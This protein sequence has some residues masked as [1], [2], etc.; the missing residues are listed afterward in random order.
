MGGQAPRE[1]ARRAESATRR[2]AP[3]VV[4]R[5]ERPPHL[6]ASRRRRVGRS[7]AIAPYEDMGVL[8]INVAWACLMRARTLQ[9]TNDLDIGAAMTHLPLSDLPQRL[10]CGQVRCGIAGSRIRRS[11]RTGGRHAVTT[12]IATSRAGAADLQLVRRLARPDRLYKCSNKVQASVHSRRMGPAR[13]RAWTMWGRVR[14][15]VAGRDAPTPASLVRSLSARQGETASTKSAGRRVR[16]RRQPAWRK[17][18][19][20]RWP[21]RRRQ[22]VHVVRW[23]GEHQHG[24][25]AARYRSSG[26]APAD[27]FTHD[28]A[29]P[30]RTSSIRASSRLLS[31][32]ISHRSTRRAGTRSSS[33]NRLRRRSRSRA[34]C[35]ARSGRRRRQGHDW[36]VMLLDGPGVSITPCRNPA[37]SGA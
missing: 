36:I 20:W 29:N 2:R 31:M 9:S 21:A 7:V 23:Q 37:K 19:A 16:V 15:A 12:N 22:V 35:R 14:A 24:R 8:A 1:R 11:T 27:T 4:R 13:T 32:K 30:N 10:G 6:A 28:P 33:S 5:R 26:G 25:W 3:C 34:R 17:E 18:A